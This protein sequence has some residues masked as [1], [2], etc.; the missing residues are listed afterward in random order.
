MSTSHPESTPQSD[1][2]PEL[3]DVAEAAQDNLRSALELA[4]KMLSEAAIVETLH[5]GLDETHIIV[6]S[7]DEVAPRIGRYTG[8]TDSETILISQLGPVGLRRA[9][10]IEKRRA[11]RKAQALRNK[12]DN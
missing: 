5:L 9:K 7:S 12:N 8:R 4:K 11:E 2:N 1:I 10:L 3:L 6:V